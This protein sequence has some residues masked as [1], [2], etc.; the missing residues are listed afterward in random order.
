ME[1]RNSTDPTPSAI[2]DGLPSTTSN[3]FLPTTA[4]DNAGI[5]FMTAASHDFPSQMCKN[6]WLHDNEPLPADGRARRRARGGTH[7]TDIALV[8][9]GTLDRVSLDAG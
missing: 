6:M 7:A 4:E 2:S 1:G 8:E 3:M 9:F 5:E